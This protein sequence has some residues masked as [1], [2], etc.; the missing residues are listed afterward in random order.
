MDAKDGGGVKQN[1]SQAMIADV[2]SAKIE[3][4]VPCDPSSPNE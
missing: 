4:R 1:E 2:G 3:D